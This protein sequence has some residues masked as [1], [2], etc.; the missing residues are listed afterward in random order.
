MQYFTGTSGS[1]QSY[2][3]I[4][5]T[6]FSVSQSYANCFRQEVG[7]CA[8][9]FSLRSTSTS[10]DY[11]EL[12][13]GAN[14][15]VPY[16]SEFF[17]FFLIFLLFQRKVGSCK[18]RKLELTVSR[19]YQSDRTVA[20]QSNEFCGGQFAIHGS[21]S[22]SGVVRSECYLNNKSRSIFAHYVLHFTCAFF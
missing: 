13:S 12:D 1:V 20:N 22:V 2:N 10:P 4:A 5:Q 7:Y 19:A 6:A 16:F 17:S 11:F 18:N 9:D 8:M 3:W 14:A 15:K 21:D